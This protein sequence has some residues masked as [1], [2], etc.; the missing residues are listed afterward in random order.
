MSHPTIPYGIIKLA[1]NGEHVGW[2]TI[3]PAPR[4]FVQVCACSADRVVVTQI[5]VVPA[6][7]YDEAKEQ[8]LS[9][10]RRAL[11]KDTP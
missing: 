10:L 7:R 6:E 9:D 8:V 5:Y 1:D 3:E 11:N 4:A 2:L